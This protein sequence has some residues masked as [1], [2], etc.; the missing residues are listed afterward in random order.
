MNSELFN[1]K[2]GNQQWR[3]SGFDLLFRGAAKTELYFHDE[4]GQKSAPESY[5]TAFFAL[6]PINPD[7]PTFCKTFKWW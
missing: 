1:V 4:R 2:I 7:Q 6:I 5:Q 3:H